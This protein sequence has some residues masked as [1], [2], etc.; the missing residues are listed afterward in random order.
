MKNIGAP[1]QPGA[2]RRCIVGAGAAPGL[3]MFPSQSRHGADRRMV[4]THPRTGP[5]GLR[6]L[7]FACWTTSRGRGRCWLTI[8]TNCVIGYQKA[9]CYIPHDGMNVNAV[10]SLKYADHLRNAEFQVE[11]SRTKVRVLRRCVSKLSGA[12]SR[13]A[14]ST[15]RRQKLAGMCWASTVKRRLTPRHWAWSR[16]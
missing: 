13:N 5:V 16:T 15:R 14:G 12:Y 3:S 4:L 6:Q 10:T 7:R 9:I 8:R 11:S 1:F 2:T